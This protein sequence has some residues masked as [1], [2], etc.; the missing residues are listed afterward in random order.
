[1]EGKRNSRQEQKWTKYPRGGKWARILLLR[2]TKRQL[3]VLGW[4]ENNEVS[5]LIP[6]P[7]DPRLTHPG[8]GFCNRERLLFLR[9]I[10]RRFFREEGNEER[11]WPGWNA[12]GFPLELYPQSENTFHGPATGDT[13][14]WDLSKPVKYTSSVSCSVVSDS[15]WPHGL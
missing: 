14:Q 9:Q 5:L 15:L 3:W 1:M 6:P 11:I 8:K 12:V 13:L 4:A 10:K 2:G 7:P